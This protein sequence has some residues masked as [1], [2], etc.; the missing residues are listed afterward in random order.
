MLNLSLKNVDYESAADTL[1]QRLCEFF[2]WRGSLIIF[3]HKFS[4]LIL[5]TNSDK[6]EFILYTG[7]NAKMILNPSATQSFFGPLSTTSSYHVAHRFASDKGM[8]LA[9][10][11]QYPHLKKCN[12]FDCSVVSDYPEEQEFLIG[13]IYMRIRKVY[14]RAFE[15]IPFDSK[16]RVSFFVVHLF[17]EMFFSNE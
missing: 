15:K 10:T 2:H 5:P 9:L 1:L 8:V 14:T 6:S 17:R 3:I 12:A 7:V 11:S 16:L 4:D 13:H